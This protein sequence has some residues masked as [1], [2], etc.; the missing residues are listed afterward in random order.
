MTRPRTRLG[1]LVLALLALLTGLLA[2]DPEDRLE[3]PVVQPDTRLNYALY[4]FRGRLLDEEGAVKLSM[5]A[6]VLRN[7]AESGVGTVEAPEIHIQ[8][9]E[10][11]WYIRAEQAIISADREQ[12]TL[13]GE[14]YL[15]RRDELTD[16][17][18][19]ISTSDV[20]LHVTPR[21]AE[22][23]SAVH[24]SQRHDRLD[25]VG[26]RLDMSDKHYEFLDDVRIHYQVP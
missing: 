16:Q 24:M 4:E 23:R 1:I 3:A 22:T 7:D 15:T 13:L 21:K 6:P 17:L 11:Q 20:V 26:M 8:Q 25:A 18:L 19:E 5:N 9:L 10:D 2:R 12:V 14:V